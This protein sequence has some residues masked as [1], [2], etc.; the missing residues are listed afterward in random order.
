MGGRG[1]GGTFVAGVDDVIPL[2]PEHAPGMHELSLAPGDH[3]DAA[4]LGQSAHKG[5]AAHLAQPAPGAQVPHD[6]GEETDGGDQ[7]HW[8]NSW[9]Q[10]LEGGHVGKIP[11]T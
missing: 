8:P 5:P 11:R 1:G 9:Q 3:H 6:R 10:L 2:G 7:G 4:A